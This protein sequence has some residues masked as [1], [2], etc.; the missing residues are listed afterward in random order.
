MDWELTQRGGVVLE[1]GHL[2]A[3]AAAA[4]PVAEKLLP[5]RGVAFPQRAVYHHQRLERHLHHHPSTP[6]VSR[7]RGGE[8]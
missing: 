8:R 3:M 6:V 7:S 5:E 2:Q 4:A 1:A